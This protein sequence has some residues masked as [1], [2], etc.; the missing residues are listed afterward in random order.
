LSPDGQI[1]MQNAQI[2]I[3]A[4]AP[5]IPQGSLQRSPGPI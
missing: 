2:S 4:R 5:Q 3:S 1:L